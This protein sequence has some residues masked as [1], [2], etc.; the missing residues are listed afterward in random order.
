MNVP[1][2]EERPVLTRCGYVP[3]ES[4]RSFEKSL[5]QAGAIST[6][7]ALHFAADIVASGGLDSFVRSLWDYAIC[8]IG[9]G[10]P[11]IFVYLRRRVRE[12]EDLLKQLPDETA[13]AMEEF[14]VRVGELVLVVRECPS[15]T[16]TPWP[17][18]GT[19]T[20]AESWI[21]SVAGNAPETA[22]L[23]KVWRPE[24]D[25]SILRTVGAELCKAIS[26]CATERALFWVKW[27]FEEETRMRKEVKGSSLS[28]NDRGLG[29]G[30][31]K[32]SVGGFVL[33][34]YSELYKELA[35]K[36]L[37]RMN[38][39]FQIL[40]NLW[41][42][43]DKRIQ[44]GAKR[45]LLAVLTQILCEVP[46]WKVPAAPP[47]IKDPVA[48]TQLIRQCPKFFREVI[49]FDP[50]PA[51]LAVQKAFRTR[52]KVD[53]KAVAAAKKGEAAVTQMDAFDRALE[54]YFSR[55]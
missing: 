7:R 13:Y 40:V 26:E 11:R 48:M 47:L 17:K 43:G 19:E 8:H 38:E 12:L 30:K 34:L 24:T 4:L 54:A 15:R 31:G 9:I 53:S 23:R 18:V 35:A 21:R 45:Q 36:G 51:G 28:T 49:A 22:A 52:G 50:P 2:E 10:S 41:K 42:E 1:V 27:L 16:A 5:S 39:E 32:G 29:G 44:G 14:Q 20:H 46:R 37:L 25:L 6:G 55:T 3:S 33:D